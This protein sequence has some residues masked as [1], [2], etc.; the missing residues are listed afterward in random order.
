MLRGAELGLACWAERIWPTRNEAQPNG[1]GVASGS[2]TSINSF[3]YEA[4]KIK[5]RAP[6]KMYA[7]FLALSAENY[8]FSALLTPMYFVILSIM[9][10]NSL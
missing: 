8:T 2:T 9:F 7:V 4:K 1:E 6:F 10:F 3:F 5:K